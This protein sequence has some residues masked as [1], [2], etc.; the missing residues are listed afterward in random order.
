[1]SPLVEAFF[2]KRTSSVQYLVA[3]PATRHCA[4]IDPVLDYDE[5]LGSVATRSADE[6]L[7]AKTRAATNWPGFSTPI[8]MPITSSRR[9]SQG[10][11]RGPDR[12]R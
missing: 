1:M 6:I 7:R 3:D 2:E 9:L 10:Q 4:V 12:H 5:T 11:V 8:P